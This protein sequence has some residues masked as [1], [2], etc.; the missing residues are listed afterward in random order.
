MTDEQEQ[1]SKQPAGAPSILSVPNV[2][3][4]VS[5]LAA[6]IVILYPFGVLIFERQ[7]EFAYALDTRTAWH[8]VTV[9]SQIE[10]VVHGLQILVAPQ[11]LEFAVI[12]IVTVATT[13]LLGGTTNDYI[14]MK[15]RWRR[16]IKLMQRPE[17]QVWDQFTESQLKDFVHSGE[18]KMERLKSQLAETNAQEEIASDRIMSLSTT[19]L[20]GQDESRRR[21][22]I[23]LRWER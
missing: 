20:G 4:T 21:R 19:T 13:G 18:Q 8:A 2:R 5:F 12:F 22:R 10:V 11:T 3:T 23:R 9:V 16:P 15:W 7:L 14:S 6:S 1:S 17:Y